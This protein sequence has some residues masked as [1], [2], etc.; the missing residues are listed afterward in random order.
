MPYQEYLKTCHAKQDT[1][2][3]QLTKGREHEKIRRLFAIRDQLV[4]RYGAFSDFF[5]EFILLLLS[6]KR[7]CAIS[8]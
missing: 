2:Y 5:V 7:F 3:Y 6:A 1:G 4:M 8:T